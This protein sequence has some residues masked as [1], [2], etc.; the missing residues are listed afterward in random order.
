MIVL[1]IPFAPAVKNL[2]IHLINAIISSYTD[3]FDDD[4][5]MAEDAQDDNIKGSDNST[6]VIYSS[7]DIF[8]KQASEEYSQMP[9]MSKMLGLGYTRLV[10]NE[11]QANKAIEMNFHD[12]FFN[13]GI[14][15]F[16]IYFAPI[17]ALLTII[18]ILFFKK[19]RYNISSDKIVG[20]FIG[21]RDRDSFG[22]SFHCRS[23]S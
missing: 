15:G 19:F 7:R 16:I 8:L 9:I 22:C 21:D 6:N 12:I 14:L 18:I 4:E 23:Y 10:D 20:I 1:V 13:F 5:N 11:V 17:L 2:N 3:F